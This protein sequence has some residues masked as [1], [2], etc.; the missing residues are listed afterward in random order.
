MNEKKEYDFLV[1]GAGLFGAV[2]AYEMKKIS[3][4]CLVIDKRP[5]IGGNIF[6]E[7]IDG[8]NVHKYGPHI[9]H[10]NDEVI[11]NYVNQFAKFNRYTNSPIAIYKGKIYNLP[12]NMNTFYQLWGIKTPEEAEK[13]L[14]EQT[15]MIRIKT[16][17]NLEEQ[18]LKL[19]GYDIYE[20]LIKGY[21][22]K[23]WGRKAT[24]LPP[25]IIKRLPVRFTYD[26]NYFNDRY[27]G[28]P[29]D[30]YTPLIES[31]LKGIEIILNTDYYESRDIW[32]RKADR[33]VY[34]GKI[35]QY[36]NYCHGNLE[37]RSLR[38]E[39]QRLNI[40]NYQGNAVANYTERS[41]P[42][43][44]IIEHKHFEFGN[45]PHTIITREYPQEWTFESEPYYPINDEKNTQIFKAYKDL[46]K[47][48]KHVFFGGRL[49][50]YQYY[51]MH[52]VIASALKKIKTIG[53]I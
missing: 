53:D 9:F 42:F 6:C 19:V 1:I 18:A 48:Q 52:Q 16:P 49:A 38:F 4:K 39:H 30:G 25:F 33:I 22:E 26:N 35:D 36:F 8:I 46:A 13:K 31:L 32:D 44:R 34:T 43:T 17:K 45:Q 24:D 50:R 2:F 5:H 51:D 20:K 27:Q 29:I 41:I 14:K 47:E 15:G 10:T 21:T 7:N 37:Y 3:K 28:I 12:F 40:Q 11:W 23:Q